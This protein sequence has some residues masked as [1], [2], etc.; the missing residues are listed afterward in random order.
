MQ[1][2]LK[3]IEEFPHVHEEILKTW[4]KE[5]CI[6]YIESLLFRDTRIERRGFP[7]EAFKTL[8]TLLE[9]YKEKHP[10]LVS[11]KDTPWKFHTP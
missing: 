6:T 2:A 1:Y 7:E 9:L 5:E 8:H 3:E 10:H 11:D 4:G